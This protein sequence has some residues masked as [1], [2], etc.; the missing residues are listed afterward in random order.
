MKKE[1]ACSEHFRVNFLHPKNVT[2]LKNLEENKINYGGKSI[3]CDKSKSRAEEIFNTNPKIRSEWI[4]RPS[5]HAN[6]N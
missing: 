4:L 2:F 3:S 6:L 1:K 5:M